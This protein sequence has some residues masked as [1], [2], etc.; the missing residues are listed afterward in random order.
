LIRVATVLAVVVIA[1][2]IM[3][4]AVHKT[5]PADLLVPKE[6][7]KKLAP[8]ATKEALD[9]SAPNRVHDQNAKIASN[10]QNKDRREKAMLPVATVH[11]KN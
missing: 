6:K 9:L 10:V 3:I 4:V 1:E 8:P 5:A 2:G 11:R 7:R